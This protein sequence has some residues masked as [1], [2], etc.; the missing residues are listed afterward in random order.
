MEY[1]S[2]RNP[3]N[4]VSDVEAIV[5]GLASDGGLFL[6][7]SIPSFPLSSLATM[8]DC[9]VSVT[10]LSAFFDSFSR[11]ELCR[12]VQAAYG[13]NFPAD[14]MVPLRP[15]GDAAVL[16]LFHGPTCAFKDVALTLLPH[17][18]TEARKKCGKTDEI[19][20]LTATSGDTGSA[21]LSGFSG[22][23]GTRIAVFYPQQGISRVQERQMTTCPAPNTLAVAVQGN[24]DD[25]QSGVKAIFRTM[26]APAGMA[27]SSA[28]SINIGRLVPQIA[29]YFMA[30]RDL[31]RAGRI[32]EG[33]PVNFVVP[34]GNFGNI[35]AGYLAGRMGLPISR[36]I[37]ASNRN[38]VLTDFFENGVY[39][40][41][42]A[43]HLTTSPS[44]DILIS[45]NLERL[46][47]LFCGAEETARYMAA[48]EQEGVYRLAPEVHAAMRQ[49]F[50]A[51]W[52]EDAE[53]ADAIQ[54]TYRTWHYVMDP[55]TAVAAVAYRKWLAGEE[56]NA[57]PTVLLATASPFKFA[58]SVLRALGE[59]P[60]GDEFADIARLSSYSGVAVPPALAALQSRPVCHEKVCRTD[61][62]PAC[63]AEF[64]EAKIWN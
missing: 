13:E 60:S 27:L 4:R 31:L 36:L 29:Y 8:D 64:L 48:L 56:A 19:C 55:H 39:D 32:Q 6:P 10:V 35:L 50:S 58:G 5:S 44:M 47:C 51:A 28:N 62:M 40:R 2:T 37:C 22:V 1:F 63:V 49:C 14:G 59:A 30:Y 17:L 61:A 34:T 12:M 24:F 52:A 38:H 18:L 57:A 26:Q 33:A 16:E 21:A 7:A 53:G 23:P 15:L 25:A 20:I 11:A 41:R 54:K 43:F 45:S 46:V 42:R 9:T 3:Q